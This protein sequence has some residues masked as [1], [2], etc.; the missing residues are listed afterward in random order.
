MFLVAAR[1]PAGLGRH[2]V[3]DAALSVASSGGGS[4]HILLLTPK[5]EPFYPAEFAQRIPG[6][7]LRVN[8]SSREV[9]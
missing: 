3:F 1:W 5:T 2:L 7:D 6:I 8:N 4:D 9:A